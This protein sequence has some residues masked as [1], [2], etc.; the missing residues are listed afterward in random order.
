MKLLKSIHYCIS[1]R[2][3][4]TKPKITITYEKYEKSFQPVALMG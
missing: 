1:N 3:N 2:F 4:L